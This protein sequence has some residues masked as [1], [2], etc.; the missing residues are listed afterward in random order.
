MPIEKPINNVV[1]KNC[2]YI[3]IVIEATPFTPNKFII[4]RLKKN[5]VIA[6]ESWLTI[7]DEPFIQ[8]S[9][10]TLKSIRGFTKDN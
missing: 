4:V 5:V 2:V 1:S 10:S 8:L 7:S 6:V 3:I 9:P